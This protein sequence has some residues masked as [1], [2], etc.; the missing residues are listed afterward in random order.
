[1]L[2][3]KNLWPEEKGTIEVGHLGGKK[4]SATGPGLRDSLGQMYTEAWYL[5]TGNQ[6]RGRMYI[7][8]SS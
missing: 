3:K 7:R 6:P 4:N 1:M 5:S 8:I 2:I